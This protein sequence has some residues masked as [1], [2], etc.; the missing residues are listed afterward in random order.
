LD[1]PGRV[2]TIMSIFEESNIRVT[3]PTSI[4]I[5]LS[6]SVGDIAFYS[7]SDLESTTQLITQLI[8]QAGV[9][10]RILMWE[11]GDVLNFGYIKTVDNVTELHYISIEVGK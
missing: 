2:D 5:P 11:D 3:T 9:G 1:K 4:Q 6:F 8:N 7:K 10:K